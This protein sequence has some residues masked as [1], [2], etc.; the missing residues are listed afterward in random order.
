MAAT[1]VVNIGSSSKKYALHLAGEVVLD[2]RFERTNTGFEMCTQRA[3]EKQVCAAIEQSG[4]SGAIATVAEKVHECLDRSAV[5]T[6]LDQVVIRVVAPGTFF[7]Q[8]A[9]IDEHYEQQLQKRASSAPLHVPHVIRELKAIQQ[10]FPKTP[11]IAA[12]D[13]AFHRTLPARA[14]EYSIAADDSCAHDLYRFGYHGLSVASVVRRIHAVIG[15]HPERLIVC[16][17]GSGTSVTAVQNG[18]SVETTMGFSPSSGLPMGSR[19][20]ELDAAAMIELMRV[21]GWKPRDAELYINTR[22]GLAG[23]AADSDIRHLLDRRSKNDPVATHA[24]DLYVYHIQ[25]AIAAQTIALGGV[26]AIVLTATASVRSSELRALLLHRLAHLGVRMSPDRNELCTG[27]DGI[28]STRNSSVKVVVMRT[29]E[30]GEM[31]CIA[32]EFRV[33]DRTVG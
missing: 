4:F 24:L 8:H 25:R 23:V 13:S 20:G 22:G 16:H 9:L 10:L 30:M 5:G 33:Q 17:I 7:Q 31:E 2:L 3:A 11:V 18:V 32:H 27:K 19:A 15:Q 26:D 1:L 12:S 6:K 28:I 29:D 14:R 21:K